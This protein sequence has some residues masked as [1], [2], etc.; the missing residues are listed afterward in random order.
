MKKLLVALISVGA[1]ITGIAQA[2]LDN[3]GGVGGVASLRGTSLLEETRPADAMK[4]YPREQAL[5]S[6][7]VYQP[8]LIPHNIRNYEVSLNAN[9]CL[10][11]HSWK[12]AS[13]MGATKISVTHFV[14][15]ED[16]VLADVSPRRY[17]CLQCHV[18]QADAKPLVKNEYERVDSLR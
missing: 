12:N 13:E 5:E 8:P 9:K 16:A 10:S 1:V 7:Y 11:C 6:D 18:P 15:R 2:E 3:P 4:K 17:F 14:N